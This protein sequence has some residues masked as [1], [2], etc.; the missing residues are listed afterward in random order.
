MTSVLKFH[1]PSA[2]FA[3]HLWRHILSQQAFFTENDAKHIKPKFSKSALN[4]SPS[5]WDWY[6]QT[7]LYWT[8]S[9]Y[10]KK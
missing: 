9:G 3:K 4:F 2:V 5:F 8:F 1:C 6:K 10:L 7:F